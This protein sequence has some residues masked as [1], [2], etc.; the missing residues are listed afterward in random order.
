M[1]PGFISLLLSKLELHMLCVPIISIWI[2]ASCEPRIGRFKPGRYCKG[3]SALLEIL[4]FF[5]N[6]NAGGLE[7]FEIFWCNFRMKNRHLYPVICEK[8]IQG[9]SAL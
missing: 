2:C 3:Y 7:I 8:N 6:D 4:L 9:Y 5:I 1:R